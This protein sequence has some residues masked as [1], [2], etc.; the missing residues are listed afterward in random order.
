[1][2]KKTPLLSARLISTAEAAKR[3]ARVASII[4]GIDGASATP[5][6]GRFLK[7]ETG[8]KGFGW[9]MDDHHGDGRVTV[10]CKSTFERREPWI[11]ADPTHA[12][13]PK[14][15]DHRG[16]VGYWLDL[17]HIDWRQ[18]T[19]MLRDAVALTAVKRARATR[20]APAA[21]RTRTS[22]TGANE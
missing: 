9:F 20:R 18:V 7:L 14:Y 22:H 10:E 15:G 13:V 2:A 17:P 12:Y 16:W 4:A 11:A 5:V 8:G 1:M 19:A 21:K 3:R 6:M